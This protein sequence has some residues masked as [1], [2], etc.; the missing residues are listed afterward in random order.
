MLNKPALSAPHRAVT[1]DG[2]VMLSPRVVTAI[3]TLVLGDN[4]DRSPSLRTLERVLG[5]S[6]C[7]EHDREVMLYILGITETPT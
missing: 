7:D 2:S 1:P 4:E 5:E 6:G 3:R